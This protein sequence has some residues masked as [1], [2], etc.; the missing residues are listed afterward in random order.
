VAYDEKLAERVRK[1]LADDDRVT[2]R[3]MFGGLCFM[4]NGNM[5]CGVMK[6]QLMARV[7]T[8]AFADALAKPGAREM[9]FTG[10][11]MKGMLYVSAEG[12]A[13]NRL[14]TWID[15]CKSNAESLPPKR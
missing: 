15:R 4:L 5:L 6:N 13:G 9:D 12:V 1:V 11:P 7:G 3:K 2:E 10:R 8:D 14:R